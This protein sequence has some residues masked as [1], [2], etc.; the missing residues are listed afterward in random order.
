MEKKEDLL[1][2]GHMTTCRRCRLHLV[3]IPT[4]YFLL[5]FIHYI[6]HYIHCHDSSI[7]TIE[8]DLASRAGKQP[9]YRERDRHIL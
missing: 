2:L 1:N 8:A 7:H 5:Y 4:I 6:R 9:L 3:L